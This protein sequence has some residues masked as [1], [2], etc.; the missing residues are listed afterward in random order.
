MIVVAL[1][2]GWMVMVATLG[3]LAWWKTTHAEPGENDSR[4][5]L[6]RADRDLRDPLMR[7]KVEDD[8]P[9]NP[10]SRLDRQPPPS[11]DDKVKLPADLPLPTVPEVEK[12]PP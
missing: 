6:L 7:V 5:P 4:E 11:A 3:G 8:R 2:V 12:P 9:G 1:A 10:P